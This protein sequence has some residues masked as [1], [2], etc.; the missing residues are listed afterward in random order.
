MACRPPAG[1]TYVVDHVLRPAMV[2][3]HVVWSVHVGLAA[4]PVKNTS[5]LSDVKSPLAPPT[6]RTPTA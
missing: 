5:S 4:F 3:V 2:G 1:S 6:R